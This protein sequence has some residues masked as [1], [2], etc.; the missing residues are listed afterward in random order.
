MS[1]AGV[2]TMAAPQ[3]NRTGSRSGRKT[4]AA[5]TKEGQVTVYGPPAISYQHAIGAFQSPPI[6][7]EPINFPFRTAGRLNSARI[8]E[9]LSRIFK[10]VVWCSSNAGYL[11][12][13]P[14]L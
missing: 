10:P 8:I 4:L 14:F 5:A 1:A 9:R 3:Q 2:E 7:A 6:S 12:P 11:I 13:T